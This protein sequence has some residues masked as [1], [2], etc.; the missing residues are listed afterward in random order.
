MVPAN[1]IR[2]RN[3]HEVNDNGDYVLYWMVAFR[4]LRSNFAFQH[5]IE[6]AARLEKP[7]LVLEALR[8]G[9]PWASDRLH[10]FILDGFIDNLTG[11]EGTPIGYHPYVEPEPGHGKGLLAALAERACCVVSDDYPAFFIPRMHDAAAQKLPVRFEVVDSN[12]LYPLSDTDRVFTV[13]HSF[14]RHLQKHLPPFLEE[15]PKPT[16]LQGYDLPP[17]PSLPE[18]ITRRWPPATKADLEDVD[19]VRLLDIDHSV[20]TVD[21]RGGS[22]AARDALET[23]L[24]ERFPRYA[25]DRNHADDDA[26]SGLSPYLHFGHISGYEIFEALVDREAWSIDDLAPKPNGKRNG[27]WNMSPPAEAFLDEFITWRE[28]GYN[29]ARHHPD[30]EAYAS[31]PEWALETLEAHASDPREYV[32]TLD[33]FENA[34]THDDIWNAAQRQLVREGKIH[35]YLRMLWGKKILE[36]TEHP[37]QAREIMV[38]LNNKWALDG[39]DPNSYSGIMWVLGRYDRAWGPERQIFGKVRYMSSESTR[40][41]IHISEYLKKYSEG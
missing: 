40:K 22:S 13:A 8:I 10:R 7:L 31:L 6:T 24:A 37:R 29:M 3:T 16:P 9:Y 39:R 2:A 17:M 35:N 32:Y 25:D 23:F 38:E 33:E 27:W 26:A 1:R 30:Y 20:P 34:R 11:L 4:R 21:L 19:L 41:K 14:R 36:W 28:V 18:A 5:A 15:F 12:G